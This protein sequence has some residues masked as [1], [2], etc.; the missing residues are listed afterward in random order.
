MKN[1][2]RGAIGV[3]AV[4]SLFGQAQAQ[5]Q[6]QGMAPAPGTPGFIQWWMANVGGRAPPGYRYETGSAVISPIDPCWREEVA[7]A[8]AISQVN[9]SVGKKDGVTA[10]V[11]AITDLASTDSI[12]LSLIGIRLPSSPSS[13]S[14]HVMLAFANGKSESGILTFNDPGQYAP[15]QVT[16]ISD[17]TIAARRAQSDR[18]ATATHL[19]VKPD[20]TSPAIQ[21]CVGRKTAL[22]AG[23]QFPGQLWVACAEEVKSPAGASAPIPQR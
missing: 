2:Y 6:A 1:A 18:L 17:F 9:A 14:C 4:L 7:S 13:V 15:L 16:W 3:L 10:Q 23:E 8:G 5:A 20:L 22:G 21:L 11:V 19:L 12:Q